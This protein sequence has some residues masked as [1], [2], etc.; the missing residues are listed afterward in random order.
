[1]MNSNL[2]AEN[3]KS[4]MQRYFSQHPKDGTG[5][6]DKLMLDL[7]TAI[8]EGVVE[9]IQQFL[10]VQNIPGTINGIGTGNGTGATTSAPPIPV[11]TSVSTKVTGT[12][13][14]KILPG[15]FR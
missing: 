9:H 2:L 1:M 15:G 8:A 4:R 5:S 14:S 6:Q 7:A 12:A 11:A 10:E 13:T 3:I